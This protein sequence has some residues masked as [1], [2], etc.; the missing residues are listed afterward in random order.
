MILS[1]K[2]ILKMP[3]NHSLSIA[4]LRKEQIQPAS[5]DIRLSDTFRMVENS[6]SGIRTMG[7]EISYKTI[8]ANQYLLLPG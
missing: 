4:P 1:Y 2:T 8:K 7:K 3:D 5:V 6:S